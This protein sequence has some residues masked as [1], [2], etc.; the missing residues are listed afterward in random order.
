MRACLHLALAVVGAALSLTV[1]NTAVVAQ[2]VDPTRP[3]ATPGIPCDDGSKPETGIQ[4]DISDEDLESGRWREGYTCNARLVSHIG[5]AGGYR[6]ERYVDAEGRECAYFDS[7][8]LFPNTIHP[9]GSGV[10]VV[11]MSDRSNPR[12]STTLL[13]PAMLT[14]H[15]SLRL[16]QR[17]GLLVAVMGNP[18]AQVGVVDVY[19]VKE[20]CLKPQL[21]STTPLGLLGHESAF[22]PDGRTFYVN[23]NTAQM[24]AIGLD[25]PTTPQLLWTSMDWSPHGASISNDGNTMFVAGRTGNVAG[26]VILD[27]SEIQQRVPNAQVRE[28]SHLTWPEVAIPQNATPFRSAGHDYV[29]E[30]DEFGGGADPVGAARIINVDDLAT[31]YVVSRLRLDIH[32][33]NTTGTERSAHYCTVPSRIDPAII[34]CSMLYS[35]LRV[36][37]IRDVDQPREVAYANFTQIGDYR[38][39][40]AYSAPAYDPESRDIWYSDANRGLLVA[41]LTKKSSIRKFAPRTF[42]PGS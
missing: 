35:G 41:H 22:A 14:P 5:S 37:D 6:V 31:P 25:D 7:G 8:T 42:L 26:L 33:K 28:I 15:E 2:G 24:A 29:M 30:V 3:P 21:L 38:I 12:L 23:S 13:T 16:N 4:G 17:R 36:F 18:A 11:D 9:D 19:S 20:N 39:G 34:A 27:V 32:N 10:W 1:A 40:N